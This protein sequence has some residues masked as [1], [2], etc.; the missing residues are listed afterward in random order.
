MK[1]AAVFALLLNLMTSVI[2]KLTRFLPSV[3]LVTLFNLFNR[4]FKINTFSSEIRVR[5]CGLERLVP[6]SRN[7][8]SS[9]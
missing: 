2:N 7:A 8:A 6:F 3:Q 9:S 1:K 4:L 5:Q